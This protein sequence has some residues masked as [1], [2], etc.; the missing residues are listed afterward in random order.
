M[1]EKNKQKGTYSL[2]WT[3]WLLFW[4]WEKTQTAQKLLKGP[5]G[6][7]KLN[8]CKMQDCM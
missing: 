4:K 6:I 7:K 2:L 8:V 5:G 1:A 3:E